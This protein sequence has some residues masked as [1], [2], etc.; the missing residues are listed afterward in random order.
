MM[1]AKTKAPYD[2]L[3]QENVTILNESP[4]T[5]VSADDPRSSP[6]SSPG[7]HTYRQLHLHRLS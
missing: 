7:P 4:V 1:I 3:G 6:L 5:T 2:R